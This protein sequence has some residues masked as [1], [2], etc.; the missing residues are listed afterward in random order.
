MYL[1]V[2]IYV[3]RGGDVNFIRMDKD[4]GI[5]G[6]AVIHHAA[7]RGSMEML[8]W[9]IAKKA[10]VCAVTS[11][12]KQTPLMLACMGMYLNLCIQLNV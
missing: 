9:L 8:Q 4:V 2:Y 1:F 3:C 12:N 5:D 11:I 10:D 6:R 7:E